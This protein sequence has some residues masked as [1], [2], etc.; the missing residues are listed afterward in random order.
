MKKLSLWFPVCHLATKSLH[1]VSNLPN[2]FQWGKMTGV[3]LYLKE[4]SMINIIV[5]L[6]SSI[7]E[8]YPGLCLGHSV[9]HSVSHSLCPQFFLPNERENILV[10]SVC[11]SVGIKYSS[12]ILQSCS[13]LGWSFRHSV[14][15]QCLFKLR[16]FYYNYFVSCHL[17]LYLN[18]TNISLMDTSLVSYIYCQIKMLF[19]L[20]CSL[21]TISMIAF[22]VPVT[23]PRIPSMKITPF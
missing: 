19:S 8:S 17:F 6:I 23:V 7:F 12:Q 13:K 1:L 2:N 22:T 21:S 16:N 11:G 9:T 4:R 5:L 10:S 18:W 15:F 3:V 20:Y 14:S